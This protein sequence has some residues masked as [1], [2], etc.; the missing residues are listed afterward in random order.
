[1]SSPHE[2]A[3]VKATQNLLDAGLALHEAVRADLDGGADLGDAAQREALEAADAAYET[4]M[5]T[6]RELAG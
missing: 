6:F 2:A 4:A 3:L 5:N 1:M